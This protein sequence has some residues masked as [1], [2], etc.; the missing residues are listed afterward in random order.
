MLALK[1]VSGDDRIYFVAIKPTE[2]LWEIAVTV[3]ALEPRE[4]AR[5]GSN[6]RAI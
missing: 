5:V 4:E 2:R 6:R 3:S 1:P